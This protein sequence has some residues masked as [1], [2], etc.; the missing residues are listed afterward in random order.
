MIF[1]FF[2]LLFVLTLVM[3][4]LAQDAA[5]RPAV[6]ILPARQK[7]DFPYLTELHQRGFN[8]DVGYSKERPITWERMK[9]YNCLVL[10]ALPL[11]QGAATGHHAWPPPPTREEF[12]PLLERYM[13]EGGGVLVLLDTSTYN[14]TPEYENHTFYLARWGAKLPLEGLYDP[15]TVA[16][17]PHSGASFIYTDRILPS[18]VSQGVKG[19]WFPNKTHSGNNNFEAY[20]QPIE[21]STDWTVVVRGSESSY[22]QALKPG[23]A[24]RPNEHF[25]PYTR[26]DRVPSPPLYAIRE[27]GGGRM[28]LS[29]LNEIFHLGSGSSW[30]HDRVMLGKGINKRPSD[31][32][33]LLENTM[34]WLAQPSLEKGTLGGYQQDPLVLKHPHFRKAPTEYFP[35]FD[36]YQNHV[37]PGSVFRGLVGAR[38][39]YSCGT[40]TVAD[41]AAAAQRA[42][43]D[44]VVFLEDF[45]TCSAEKLK[46]LEDECKR[47]SSD[48]L[49]LIAGYTLQ[50]NLGNHIFFMGADHRWPAP[51]QLDGPKKDRLRL[52]CFDKDGKLYY[53]DEDAKN[54]LWHYAPPS[55]GRN[56]GY[57]NFANS[58]PG[59]VPVRNLRL[60]GMLGAVTYLN[61]KFVEDVTGDYLKITPQGNAPRLCAVELVNSP[62]ELEAAV[63]AG[64]YLTHVSA[65]ALSSLPVY[66][67]YGH[68]YGVHNCNPST[69]PRIKA[70]AG[71]ERVLTFA[72]EPFV[73][74]RYRVRPLAWVI[75]DVGLKELKIY[76]DGRLYRR[77]L[78]NGDKE[79][80][81]EFEW[82]YDRQ[83]EFVLEAFDVNG[84]RAFSAVHTSW[85]DANMNTWCHDRQNGELWHGPFAILGPWQSGV[86]TFYSTGRTWDGG[87][88][89]TPFAGLNV[90]THPGLWEKNGVNEASDYRPMEGYTYTTCMDDSCRNIA[91]EAWNVYAPGVVANAYITLGP[92]HPAEQMTFTL[93]RTQ[94][95]PRVV[96]PMLDWHAMWS[97]REGGGM[98][99][100]EGTMTL[101]KD[102]EL[103]KI[104][105]GQLTL[106]NFPK[107]SANVPWW[108]IRTSEQTAPLCGPKDTFASWQIHKTMGLPYTRYIPIERGGYVGTFGSILGTPSA[109]F[110]VG[111]TALLYDAVY[112]GLYLSVPENAYKAGQTF[113]WRYLYLFDNMKHPS[114]NLG[115]LERI[116]AY[117][118][119][120]GR[121]NTAL[122]VKQGTLQSHFGLPELAP[123]N[124]VVEFEAPEPNFDLDVPLCLRFLGFNPNWTVGQYQLSGY[125]PG[126]YSKGQQVYRNLAP[127]DKN[128]VHLAVYTKGVPKTHCLV[129]HPVQC[130]HT[131][132]II[133][134]TK[135]SDKPHQWH[136]AVNNITDKPIT[137][138]L[139]KAMDLPGFDFPDTPVT[140]PA[141]GY[142]VVKEK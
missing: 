66:M 8:V 55:G 120:D 17:H 135:L 73:T 127:D 44:F 72:G 119:L 85:C 114:R 76:S 45:S 67:G 7:M 89:L 30:A 91:G 42:G 12:L 75:S 142:I 116:R 50:T 80:K 25:T 18:P 60:Y 106:V 51:S 47:L 53:N 100:F 57:F 71:C 105:V 129:G 113:T 123:V 98:V 134:V 36:S 32:H 79:F 95:L 94:Y 1:R 43:L 37:P 139:K 130:D 131:N 14:V 104:K 141:G 61:G 62:K 126:F 65:P 5:K 108:A 23:F 136:V 138:I 69:G 118:G 64:H 22:A 115:R 83:R 140:V 110:N 6:W 74:A 97:E 102:M 90:R 49:L 78:L 109:V 40:G 33:V 13:A 31:F 34:R 87:G 132:L 28:G 112:D 128:I 103:G 9:Q 15:V 101:K 26:P 10:T 93:R 24:L 70:W 58:S 56:I 124:G 11:P 84:G 117:F 137:T 38:T 4:A 20:G 121:G 107:E 63:A 68:Q 3:P 81:R 122:V 92:T 29:V 41:Y 59:S 21:V 82:A 2:A 86:I 99:M 19:I 52:Q 96:G 27:I 39:T 133:E 88:A 54:L 35:E 46:R 111:E 16:N 48:K 125:S 77:I